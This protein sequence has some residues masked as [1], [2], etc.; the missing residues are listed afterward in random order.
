MAGQVLISRQPVVFGE[1]SSM[2]D[3]PHQN[4]ISQL[5]LKSGI[6]IPLIKGDKILAVL[7]FFGISDQ[8]LSQKQMDT[9]C[10][11]A[12][13]LVMAGFRNEVRKG[14]SSL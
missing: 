9:F 13:G 6:S 12:N 10:S 5:G 8:H 1:I 14:I 4:M 3:Y 2:D 7:V 11:Y